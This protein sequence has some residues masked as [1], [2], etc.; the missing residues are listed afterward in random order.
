M[1]KRYDVNI[2]QQ[3]GSRGMSDS[4]E[5]TELTNAL[6]GRAGIQSI[7]VGVPL[8][9]FL[10]RAGGPMT[11][12]VLAKTA[13]MSPS[14]AHK[15]LTSFQRCGLVDQ[16]RDGRYKLGP[17]TLELGFSALRQ[18][19]VVKLAGPVMSDLRDL[20]GETI[21]MTLWSA[22]GVIVVS[23]M[24]FDRPIG[25]SVR[26]GSRLPLLDSSNG[27]IF[28]AF[29]SKSE[30]RGAVAREQ[31]AAK[32]HS[33]LE[34]EQIISQVRKRGLAVSESRVLPGIMGVSAPVFGI[35]GIAAALTVV[36]IAGQFDPRESNEAVQALKRSAGALSRLLGGEPYSP[37]PPAAAAQPD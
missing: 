19:D 16:N 32:G 21:V 17:T 3:Q 12:S 35:Q 37:Q 24:E 33:Q 15:Y 10:A 36:A 31:P 27:Q 20:V 34:I 18:M 30:L 8:L 28:A 7:E 29:M 4:R 9:S 5:E 11:L 26:V 14:K 2:Q 13:G 23:A 1:R 25:V 22:I 6:A